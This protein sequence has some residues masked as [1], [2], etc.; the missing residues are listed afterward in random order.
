MTYTVQPLCRRKIYAI[1]L[2]L[3]FPNGL[4]AGAGSFGN[5]IQP[6]QNGQGDW[7]LHGTAVA[8]VLRQ[9]FRTLHPEDPNYV[10]RFFGSAHGDSD[11]D[12]EDSASRLSVN[13][14][15]AEAQG[16]T[17]RRENPVSRLSVDDAVFKREKTNSVSRVSHLRFFYSCCVEVGVVY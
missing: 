8:G 4:C 3:V 10:E 16:V 11:G 1:D 17:D 12:S 5:L 9:A 6:A 13:D 15:P 2:D 7:V 14:A